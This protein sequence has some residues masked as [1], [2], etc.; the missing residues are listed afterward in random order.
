MT[1]PKT[2]L[3][4]DIPLS[5]L[6]AAGFEPVRDA[7]IANFENDGELGCQV[8][9][10]RDGEPV[11]D[12]R[13]GWTDRKKTAEVAPDTLFSVYSS[14]KAMAAL[15]IA[16]LVERGDLE[17]DR[18]VSELW[19]EFGAHGKGAL[20][21]AQLMSHQSGLS[22]ITDPT[23]QPQDWID[24]DRVVSVL[25]DQEPLFEPGSRSGYH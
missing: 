16:H 12:L 14:G 4:T 2:D 11:V 13:A 8:A 9:I 24:F 1:D 21:V 20:T 3:G 10:F 15:V 18:R 22:G 25:E 7:V 19:P 23:F 17:Y 6:V 5:G